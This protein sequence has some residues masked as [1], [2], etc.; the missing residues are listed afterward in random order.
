MQPPAESC[1]I[2]DLAGCALPKTSK[3]RTVKL[4]CSGQHQ[5]VDNVKLWTAIKRQ[6]REGKPPHDPVTGGLFSDRQL[7]YL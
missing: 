3:R 7:G 1:I 6:Q 2:S 4:V 5:C